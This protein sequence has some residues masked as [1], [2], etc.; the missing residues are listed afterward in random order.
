MKWW[1]W[2]RRRTTDTARYAIEVQVHGGRTVRVETVGAT[3]TRL[4]MEYLKEEG[5][6]WE[7][8]RLGWHVPHTITAIRVIDGE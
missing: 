1:N 6:V 3:A 2:L 7:I 5:I 4:Q 8:N